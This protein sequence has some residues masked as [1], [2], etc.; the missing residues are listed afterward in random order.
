MQNVFISLRNNI[1]SLGMRETKP[2]PRIRSTD[3]INVRVVSRS[4]TQSTG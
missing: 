4:N 2:L 1:A 3:F